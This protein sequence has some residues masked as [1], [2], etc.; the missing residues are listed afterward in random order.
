VTLAGISFPFRKEAGQF[1]KKDLDQE[2]VRSNVIALFNLPLRSRIMR[3]NL[4][5]TAYNLVFE[6]I[7]PLLVTRLERSIRATL[8]RGEPRASVVSVTI[9][10][11][12]TQLLADI[13]YVVTGIKNT[14]QVALDKGSF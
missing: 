14:V 3:P 8:E 5:T 13:V 6:P 9:S 10:Q 12:N 11:N 1:P 2:A 7:T 4:G